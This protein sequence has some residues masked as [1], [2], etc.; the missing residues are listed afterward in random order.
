MMIKR[1][2]SIRRYFKK[3]DPDERV[4][5]ELPGSAD[6]IK[7]I[8]DIVYA[9]LLA[10]AILLTFLFISLKVFCYFKGPSSG[11]SVCKDLSLS[12]IYTI[13]IPLAFLVLILLADTLFSVIRRKLILTNKRIL[14]YN[15]SWLMGRRLRIDLQDVQSLTFT[16]QGIVYQ[17]SQHP[18]KRLLAKW[19]S[20]KE[21]VRFTSEFNLFVHK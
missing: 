17:T 19:P 10:C 16:R 4:I 20:K 2:D 6:L 12:D 11:Q 21:A 9:Y 14:A 1:R 15:G 13:L 7:D 18:T 8:L 3:V 5:F